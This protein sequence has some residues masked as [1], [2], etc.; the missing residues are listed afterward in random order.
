MTDELDDELET[1]S[2]YSCGSDVD[3]DNGFNVINDYNYCYEC[4]ISCVSCSELVTNEDSIGNEYCS[5]CGFYCAHCNESSHT[6]DSYSVDDNSWCRS[7]YENDTFYCDGCENS[8]PD[9]YDNS[10]VQG[11]TYCDSCYSDYCYWCDECDESFLDDSPCQHAGGSPSNPSGCH[12]RNRG[13][14][15]YSCKPTPIF[16]GEPK[17]KLYMGFELE[18]EIHGEYSESVTYANEQLNGIALLQHDSSIGRNGANG[19]EIVTHP[20]SHAYYRENSQKLWDTLETLRTK[21]KARS[22]D[23]DTCGL[24]IHVSRAGFSSGAH[25]HRFI[26][27]VYKNAEMMMKF[28]GRKSSYA[29][30]NDVWRFDEY[31]RPI[32]SI[33]HKLDKHAPT[34]RYS[35]VNTQNEHTL[36][37]RFFRGTMNYDGVLS[38]LDL[39][40][41]MV[42]YTR[43]LRFSDVQMGAL[44][45]E[46]F[47]DYVTTNN[48]LYPSLYKRIDKVQQVNI[49]KHEMIEAQIGR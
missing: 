2:C 28:G 45:W 47:S 30:F 41:A 18:T 16:L 13:V 25:M 11:A 32:F 20:H 43:E 37:L 6:D 22:W 38:A 14:H 48:G 9:I 12:C 10:Y 5:D 46:W 27:F 31:D 1:K 36:E 42:E 29:R 35:A 24:H 7:C 21:Y 26:A 3:D 23:T 49:N 8:Y 34:E 15:D 33:K 17:S 39:T 40:Q 4:S 44:S 19:Y